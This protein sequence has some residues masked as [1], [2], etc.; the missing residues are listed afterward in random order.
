MHIFVKEFDFTSMKKKI[1]FIIINILAFNNFSV[2]QNTLD[3]IINNY[4]KSNQ[5][6]GA[7]IGV[8]YKDSL[9]HL[10]AYGLSD[11]QNNSEVNNST[12]FELGSL[13]KQFTACAILKLYQ[14]QKLNIEDY[15]YTHFPECPEHW[16][17]IKIKHLL[18]HTSGLPG[19]FPHD[20]YIQNSFTGYAKMNSS[21]LDLMMK[22]NT[23]SKELAIQSIISDSLDFKPGTKFN[24]SD[25]G[26]L[27]LG[28]VIDNITGSYR[29]YMK[30]AI[31]AKSNLKNTYLL[32]QEKV[33][34]N[35]ARGYSLKNGELINI[36]RTWDYEIPSFFGVFSNVEDLLKWKKVLESNLL[37]NE[38]N[39]QLL[40][41][42]G[43]LDNGTPIE[44]GFGWEINNINNLKMISHNGVTGTKM[45]MIPSEEFC[46]I[47]LT[48][49]GYNGNDL[50]DPWSLSNEI[51]N[52]YGIETKINKNHITLA[53]YKT[54][55]VKKK[56]LKNLEGTYS[57]EDGLQAKITIENGVPFLNIQDSKNEMALL[58]NGSWLVLGM[59]YEYTLSFNEIDG[60][61]VSNY[62]RI[63]F[64][65]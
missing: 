63:Y 59:E 47:L 54:V 38:A 65:Q 15:L 42:P 49:L 61:L 2:A 41:K 55:P 21:A 62:G 19:M 45:I 1:A 14:E 60:S 23:V 44:Y 56:N 52:Y 8:Y 16:K 53:G 32:N 20:D 10:N 29:D 28:I 40:F 34:Q 36:M 17:E 33:V 6:P 22:N 27:I 5:I 35:Q 24:Y 12:S 51:L 11:V 25:V 64:K 50:V 46:L 7:V 57:T 9:V 43:Y 3:K 30:N 18:W 31:F 26:Y 37:L 13:T 58:S 4:L 48:N 39:R